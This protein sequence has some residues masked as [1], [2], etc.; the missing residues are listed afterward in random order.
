[1][2]VTEMN[3]SLTQEEV[4][5]QLLR[6]CYEHAMQSNHPSTHNAALLV[7]DATVVMRGINILPPGVRPI[8]ERSMGENKHLYL[9]HAERDVLY[10][11]A[12]S[13]IKTEALMMVMPWLPCIPCANAIITSGITTLLVHKQMIEKTSDRWK[14]EITNAVQILQEAGVTICAY[15]GTIG[16]KAFM[17]D[18]VWNA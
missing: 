4:Y 15:D 9:N 17:H 2:N 7:Q 8:P 11:A 14:E 12:R 13:G 18:Q 1:M 5:K 16:V 10:K 3:I 6:D